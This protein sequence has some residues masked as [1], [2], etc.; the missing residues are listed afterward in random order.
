[1]TEASAVV[2]FLQSLTDPNQTDIGLTRN[3]AAR[4]AAHN[5]E[6]SP[7]TAK[8][9]PWSL[10]VAVSFAEDK[11]AAAFERYLKTGS[12]RAFASRHFWSARLRQ[13]THP[14]Y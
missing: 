7:H 3:L 9:A 2:Y 10:V 11:S 6:A 8:Y 1:M 13:A 4:L 12:G 5:R 14:L